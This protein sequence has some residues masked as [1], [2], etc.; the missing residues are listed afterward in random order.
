[1]G[2]RELLE[3]VLRD[4]LFTGERCP[5]EE[6]KDADSATQPMSFSIFRNAHTVQA[7]QE[8][9]MVVCWGGHSISEEEYK[10]TKE[11][12]YQLEIRGLNIYTGCGGAEII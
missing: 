11:V 1:M 8:P 2:I 4:I 6:L 7:M 5:E 9:D 12:G 3:S 10:Y